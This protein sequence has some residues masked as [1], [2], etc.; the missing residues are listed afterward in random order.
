MERSEGAATPAADDVFTVLMRGADKEEQDRRMTF[1]AGQ[2][3]VTKIRPFPLIFPTMRQPMYE[4]CIPTRG[5]QVPAGPD[6]RFY[7][8]V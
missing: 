5:T 6:W 4:P 8:M 7:L 2:P 3:T 1:T